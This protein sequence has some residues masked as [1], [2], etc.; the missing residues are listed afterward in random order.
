[1]GNGDLGQVTVRRRS[2]VPFPKSASSSST[3]RMAGHLCATSWAGR[4]QMKHSHVWTGSRCS[5]R[6]HPLRAFPSCS[7]MLNA[8]AAKKSFDVESFSDHG[9]FKRLPRVFRLHLVY[10]EAFLAA[11][12]KGC[13]WGLQHAEQ[14]V[15][16]RPELLAT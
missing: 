4:F 13:G 5:Q 10:L 14:R 7:V 1:M 11:N 2:S 3:S 8:Y 16:N 6:W 15:R 12:F 9:L